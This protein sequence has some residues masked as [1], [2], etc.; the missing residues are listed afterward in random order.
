VMSFLDY[1]L[2]S[3][4]RSIFTWYD[5]SFPSVNRIFEAHSPLVVIVLITL[6]LL[7]VE[8]LRKPTRCQTKSSTRR[9]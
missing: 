6:S 9:N 1:K 2:R 3:K 4:P 5:I 7:T 8:Q